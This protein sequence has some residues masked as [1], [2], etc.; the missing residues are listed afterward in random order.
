VKA[1]RLRQ[2]MRGG[3]RRLLLAPLNLAPP[4]IAAEAL[5]QAWDGS[6]VRT[7]AGPA[8]LT[9]FAP[10]P[11]LRLRA[12]QLLTKE[13]ETI[14]WLDGLGP[15]DVLWDVGANVGMFSLYAAAARSCTVLAFEPSAANYV[16]LTRNI[17][18]NQLERHVTAYALALSGSTSLGV[19]NLDSTAMGTAMNE[20][21]RAGDKSP[22]SS[23]ASPSG[24]GMIGFTIDEFVARFDPPA[25]THI[26]LDVDG[27]EWPILQGAV[28]TLTSPR[29][30][31]IIVELSITNRGE[32]DRAMTL[33]ASCGLQLKLQAQAQGE[34]SEQGANHLF[35]RA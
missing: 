31:S 26:K 18:I 1:Q 28:A 32:R 10:T 9:F 27:L 6:E 12:E 16:V 25:P 22:Y 15:G 4:V 34:A 30:K 19:L 13:P 24:H 23:N 7:S 29:L 5:T 3:M 35:V 8:T 21:G 20:F 14:A 33:L 17:Q 2:M 11:L